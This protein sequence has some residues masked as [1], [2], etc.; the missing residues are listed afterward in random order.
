LL[1]LLKCYLHAQIVRD[2]FAGATGPVRDAVVLNASRP[3]FRSLRM[4]LAVQYA[5]D[6]VA[7][8]HSFNDIPGESIVPPAVA[9][10]FQ[11]LHPGGRPGTPENPQE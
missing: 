3:L 8:A 7:L 4:R 11:E 9:R 10:R 6:R 5:F 1:E 2:V